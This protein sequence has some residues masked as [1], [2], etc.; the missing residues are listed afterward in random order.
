MRASPGNPFAGVC[1]DVDGTTTDTEAIWDD[2]EREVIENHAGISSPELIAS[3]HGLPLPA[4]AEIIATHC[5][6]SNATAAQIEKELQDHFYDA[7]SGRPVPTRPG[8]PELLEN[9]RRNRVPL[10]AVS[11]TPRPLV[12]LALRGA[13][14]FDFFDFT[15]CAGDNPTARPKPAPDLYNIA[16][17]FLG[18]DRRLSWGAE[19][20]ETGI[21]AL[22]AADLFPVAVQP[23]AVPAT[24][25]VLTTRTLWPLDLDHL[26]AMASCPR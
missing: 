18:V 9:L 15:V 13:G 11:N 16:V 26:F 25:P 1:L 22:L 20:T 10:A 2:V 4:T 21:T 14:L 23:G 19:D 6:G 17:N 7:L 24:G 12:E 8:A 5:S 3:F